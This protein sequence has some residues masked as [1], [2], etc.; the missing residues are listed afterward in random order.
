MTATL[1]QEA[2]EAAL[3]DGSA[4]QGAPPAPE[5]TT[6]VDAGQ[7]PLTAAQAEKLITKAIKA[8]LTFA[9]VMK[10]IVAKKAWEPLGYTDPRHMMRERFTGKLINPHTG[11]PFAD[12]YIRRMS[13]VAWVLWSLADSTGIDPLEL[14]VNNGLLAQIPGGLAGEK[15]EQ[16]VDTIL[17]EVDR[18]GASEVEE[19]QSVIDDTLRAS[20]EA[21]KPTMPEPSEGSPVVERDDAGDG[22]YRSEQQATGPARSTAVDA[23]DEDYAPGAQAPSPSVS[24]QDALAMMRNTERTT[25]NVDTLAGFPTMLRDA[26][27]RIVQVAPEVTSMVDAV[28]SAGKA[29]LETS[30]TGDVAGLFDS[31]DERELDEL[32]EQVEQ[33]MAN[34]ERI[35]TAV[36]L[37]EGLAGE[38][39]SFV[40]ASQAGAEMASAVDRLGDF[41]D[42]IDFVAEGM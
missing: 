9:D 39:E 12:S 6:A 27:A 3:S 38:D 22:G 13:N 7:G 5:T 34:A 16:L 11:E 35:S 2:M 20:A 40:E 14:S 25:A 17:D 37:L 4:P 19:V 18:R 32:R 28:V 41:L 21:K 10:Q 31:L 30:A 42:E 26:A 36:S 24:M 15:H 8:A 33:A 1:V 23:F 29:T